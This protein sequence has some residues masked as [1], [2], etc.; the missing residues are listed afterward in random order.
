M[1]HKMS[2]CLRSLMLP[3]ITGIND[4]LLFHNTNNW[5]Y[6]RLHNMN[7]GFIYE[8]INCYGLFIRMF[9]LWPVYLVLFQP[10]DWRPCSY[11]TAHTPSQPTNTFLRRSFFHYMHWFCLFVCLF[12][13]YYRGRSTIAK[14]IGFFLISLTF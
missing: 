5:T 6:K 12:L 1:K 7:R 8:W 2:D 4:S 14:I 9:M 11:I 3:W 13:S 10:Q